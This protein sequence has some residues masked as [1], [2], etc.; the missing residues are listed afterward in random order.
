VFGLLSACGAPQ[1]TTSQSTL[2]STAAITPRPESPRFAID[3][4]KSAMNYVAT[5]AGL[6]GFAQLPGLF[7]LKGRAAVF[8]PE[9]DAYRIRVDLVID[10]NTATALNTLFLN[11]L[12]AILEIDKFRYAYFEGDSKELV[13]LGPGPT[14]FTV[15][16]T[17]DLHGHKVPL[18][19]PLTMTIH[20][21]VIQAHGDVVI[22]LGDY[23]CNV[24]S[25]VMSTRITFKIEITA[26]KTTGTS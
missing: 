26:R 9:G 4:E 23:G 18:E 16:G 11:Q 19:M 12:W 1:G 25:A 10:G 24:P 5:G 3:N 17:L 22:D 6:F 15:A 2:D 8:V 13:T 7:R 14:P 21:G 20:D